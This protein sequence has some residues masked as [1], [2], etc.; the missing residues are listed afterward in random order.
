MTI[1]LTH[2]CNHKFNIIAKSNVI[3]MVEP[4]KWD[5]LCKCRCMRCGVT[6]DQWFPS[7]D[8]TSYF[9]DISKFVILEWEGMLDEL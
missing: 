8:V 7:Y 6:D 3:Q 1:K 5:R 9:E 4:G 2:K